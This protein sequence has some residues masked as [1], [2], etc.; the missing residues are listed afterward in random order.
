MQNFPSPPGLRGDLAAAASH[1]DARRPFRLWMTGNLAVVMAA[2]VP[3][4]DLAEAERSNARQALRHSRY[5]VRE[6]VARIK[7][8]AQSKGL[9]ILALLGGARPVIV[10]A[11][12]VGGTP[13]VMNEA[14]SRPDM[15]LCVQVR[16]G[17]R[18]H[19]EVLTTA[20]QGV[21]DPGWQDLP[22]AVADDLAALPGLLDRALT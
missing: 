3:I 1:Q 2:L 5:G 8:E 14:N 18:G 13:V 21:L 11:S 12:S 22:A 16:E 10:L 20:L 6:T 15:P 9:S 17:V 7:A 4:R 19:A